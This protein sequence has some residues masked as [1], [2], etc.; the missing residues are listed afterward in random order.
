M[1]G[2]SPQILASEKKANPKIQELTPHLYKIIVFGG[3]GVLLLR[4]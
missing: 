2:P 1:V 3:D 4:I